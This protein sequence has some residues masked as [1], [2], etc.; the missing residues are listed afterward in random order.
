M[1]KI[2]LAGLKEIAPELA[3]HVLK[4]N[5]QYVFA[6]HNGLTYAVLNEEGNKTKQS[7]EIGDRGWFILFQLKVSTIVNMK[8]A[9]HR[10]RVKRKKPLNNG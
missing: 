1:K 3:T 8:H 10:H 6:H 4:V 9:P 2:S 7:F 5:G